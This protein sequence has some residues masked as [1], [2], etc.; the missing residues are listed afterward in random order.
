MEYN[1]DENN[2]EESGQKTPKFDPAGETKQ[3]LLFLVIAVICV[4]AAKFILGL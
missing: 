4:I 3:K 1:Q 2:N